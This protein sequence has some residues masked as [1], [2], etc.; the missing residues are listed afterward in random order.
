MKRTILVAALLVLIGSSVSAQSVEIDFDHIFEHHGSIMLLLDAETGAI[1]H[2]NQAASDFYG[3]TIKELESMS[4]ADLDIMEAE[5]VEARMETAVEQNLSSVFVEHRL[6]NGESAMCRSMHVPIQW[7][8][9]TLF[10]PWSMTLP[11]TSVRR[12]RIAGI[13]ISFSV[14]PH[15]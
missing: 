8:A 9:L 7:T 3:Y 15:F 14:C 12:R 11:I 4:L 1:I 5:A 2:A 6:A 10:L 13:P